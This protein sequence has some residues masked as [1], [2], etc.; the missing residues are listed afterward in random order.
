MEIFMRKLAF[1]ALIATAGAMSAYATDVN[2]PPT[3]PVAPTAPGAPSAPEA[4]AEI[5]MEKQTIADLAMADERFATLVD[6]LKAAGLAE[7]LQASG[8]FTVFAPTNE[9]FAAAGSDTV[10]AWMMPENK[11]MLAKTLSYHVVAGAV[12][13]EDLADG[14]TEV[15]TLEGGMLTVVKSA[16][17]VTVNGAKVVE[18]DITA[19]NGVIHAI[20]TVLMPKTEPAQ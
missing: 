6:A 10:A 9:A 3:D 20:D 17:G 14:K 1:A 4:G 13:S 8:P 11:A 5:R 18:A 12:R 7:T 2:A 19:S 16:D 15:P